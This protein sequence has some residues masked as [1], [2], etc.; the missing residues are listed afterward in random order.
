[1]IS[2][3][4]S[5]GNEMNSGKGNDQLSEFVLTDGPASAGDKLLRA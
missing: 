4:I 3:V 2:I 5:R 1:M